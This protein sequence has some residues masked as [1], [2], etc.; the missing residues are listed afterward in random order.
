MYVRN[1]LL[2][3]R[4][5]GWTVDVFSQEVLSIFIPELKE[6]SKNCFL[7][8]VPIYYMLPKKQRN[9]VKNIAHKIKDHD[10]EEIIIESNSITLGLLAENVSKVIGAKHFIFVLDEKN[11]VTNKGV[12]DYL[13][14]KHSRR[15][16]VGI[17][18]ISLL[19]MFSSFYPIKQEDSY[20]LDAS[21]L[22]CVA[23]VDSPF[24]HRID[25]N[26]Y[27]YIVGSLTR[28]NKSFVI[29]AITEFCD[30][31][32]AKKDKKF[33]LI[34]IGDSKLDKEQ[35]PRIEKLL[36]SVKH[37][38][39]YI[40]TGYVFPV[41]TR[42]LELCDSLFAS[43]GSA[44]A[45]MCSGVP[46]IS[47]D[48]NDCK[49]IGVLG[50]TTNNGLFRNEDEPSLSFSRL[51]DDILVSKKFEKKQSTFNNVLPDYKAHLEFLRST[52]SRKE[53]FD[54]STIKPITKSEKL[55][56]FIFSVFGSSTYKKVLNMRLKIHDVC[57]R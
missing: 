33:L 48:G 29:P 11:E 50:R 9:L 38:V 40:I 21:L 22:G 15:E 51:L 6:F 25:R 34:L 4:E 2:Y 26:K 39:E 28:L 16:L 55:Y 5:H 32:K 8:D 43:S 12:Q 30:Y 14:F 54:I 41:P 35:V 56:G 7:P 13:V 1:K 44:Y 19:R 45:C 20:E 42:L 10:Y 49:P 27:D 53:Y 37:N 24:I 36:Q 57:G 52:E 3:L 17:T 23:D 47:F 31:A 46:T 18:K